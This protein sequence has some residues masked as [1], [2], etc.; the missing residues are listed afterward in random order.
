MQKQWSSFRITLLL[1]V[2]V[3]MLPLSFYYVYSSF[4]TIKIDTSIVH[5]SSWIPGAIEHVSA[6]HDQATVAQIDKTLNHI[7][8]WA[9]Q[10][11]DSK[12][13]IGAKSLSQDLADVTACW[14]ASKKDLSGQKGKCY[15]LAE[16]MAVNI[17]KMVYMK[18]KEIINI[19]YV[20]L[21]L[22]MIFTLL[23]IYLVRVYIHRQMK[24]HAIHDHDTHLFNKKYFLAQLH[25]AVARA[26]RENNPLSM[27]FLSV[28]NFGTY[29]AQQQKHLIRKTAHIL[30]MITRDS[31]TVCR[32]NENH[33]AVLM[34][35]TDNKHAL[36][37]EERMKKALH[38]YDFHLTP[39][40]E[41]SFK[42][43]QLNDN[44]TEEDFILR[45]KN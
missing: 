22:A 9:K 3:L 25:T 8:L 42:T 27:F 15:D 41:L 16:N 29:N 19:F 17:E 10:N 24:K 40:P 36:H 38:D 18:Q 7:S 33:F 45:S 39:E 12:L 30:N 35:L 37:L 26:K 4:E 20:S 23:L 28:N 11:S 5:Q 2:V 14:N 43:T 44:E 1:Y 6:T 31:D 32:Y 13:Y 34:P 21:L